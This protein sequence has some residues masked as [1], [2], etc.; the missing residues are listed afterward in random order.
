MKN[1]EILS[2]V[3]RYYTNK[4]RTHGA[5]P[6]GVDWNSE[7]GQHLRFKALSSFLPA[8]GFS[9]ID[10]GCGYGSYLDYLSKNHGDFRYTGVDISSEMIDRALE[11]HGD[12]EDARFIKGAASEEKADFVVASGIF[13]VKQGTSDADWKRYIDDCIAR[14]DSDS[15]HG[16]AFNCLTSYSDEHRKQPHLYYMQ[17]ESLFTQCMRYSSNLTLA[18]G[19]GLYEMTMLVRKGA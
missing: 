19:Y 2:D 14:M 4:V 5:S 11:L 12:R 3:E 7:E 15:T 18:H 8:A 16:F 1:A 13:N 10:L 9:I 17:P 6:R